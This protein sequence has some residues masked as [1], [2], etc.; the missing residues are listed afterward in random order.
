MTTANWVFKSSQLFKFV[1]IGGL[2]AATHF[3]SEILL[4]EFLL[5]HPLV[6]NLFAFLI[7][8]LVSF[9]GQRFVTFAESNQSLQTSLLRF[10]LVAFS[11]FILNQLLF[12]FIL[13]FFPFPYYLAL[14][15]VLVSVAVITFF[16]SKHWA[17][18]ST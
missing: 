5:L 9:F 15:I 7:A 14:L 2:A 10:F 17:F 8:F 11:S 1:C 13:Y 4:V 12:A 16:A 3:L 6:A 18:A